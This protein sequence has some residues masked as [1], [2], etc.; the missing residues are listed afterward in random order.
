L[1]IDEELIDWAIQRIDE[2]LQE[3]TDHET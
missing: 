2:T 1:I 3:L